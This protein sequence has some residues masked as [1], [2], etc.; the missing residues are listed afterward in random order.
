MQQGECKL[1]HGFR[2]FEEDFL[3][4]L[5]LA[6]SLA[7]SRRLSRVSLLALALPPFNPP[8]RP[9]ATAAGFLPLIGGGFCP[10]AAATI[11]AAAWLGSCGGCW[12]RFMVG[13][14]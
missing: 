6:P 13:P 7:I 14:R 11:Q 5:I 2:R 4:H 12:D 8:K 10:V 1:Y 9:S 3:P